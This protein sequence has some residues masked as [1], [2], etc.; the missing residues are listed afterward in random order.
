MPTHPYGKASMPALRTNRRRPDDTLEIGLAPAGAHGS[1]TPSIPP[2]A[3][4]F[5]NDDEWDIRDFVH[6]ALKRWARS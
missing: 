6:S 5:P 3:E 2:E 4:D 1:K